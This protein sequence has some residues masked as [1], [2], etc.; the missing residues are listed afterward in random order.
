MKRKAGE[1]MLYLFLTGNRSA[2]LNAIFTVLHFPKNTTYNLKYR[3][4]DTKSIVHQSA[5]NYINFTRTSGE[6]TLILFDNE[7]GKYVPLRFGKLQK[8]S[9]EEGQIYYS[10]QLTEYC[11]TES[12]SEFGSFIDSVSPESVR[13]L[14]DKSSNKAEGI[15]AFRDENNRPLPVNLKQSEDSW[16]RT[17]QSLSNLMQ[18]MDIFKQ[19][20]LIFTKMEIKTGDDHNQLDYEEGRINL[21]SGKNYKLHMNYYIPEFN[22]S[23][24]ESLSV[25]FY[26][27]EESIGM[28]DGKEF[29]LS[30]QN[31][32]D[33]MCFPRTNISKSKKVKTGFE[34]SDKT[35]KG[36]TIQYVNTPLELNLKPRMQPVLRVGIIIFLIAVSFWGTCLTGIKCGEKIQTSEKILKAAGSLL[37]ALSTFGMI[38]FMGK[39]KL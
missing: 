9:E 21:K 20:Y 25:K 3:L 19:Y 4:T 28:I 11:H 18:K 10:V 24:M 27:S 38:Y 14:T 37:T 15:L 35:V 34:I 36:K 1:I 31:K 39:P 30:Q 6:E 33:I 17:V 29:M 22:E 23:P 7:E 16:I 8:Y 5:K 13:H 26:Q 32:M 12:E 2:Y